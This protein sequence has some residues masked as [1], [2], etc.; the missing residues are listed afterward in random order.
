MLP[1]PIKVRGGG[2]K[3]DGNDEGAGRSRKRD[4][5]DGAVKYPKIGERRALDADD[6]AGSHRHHS[7]SRVSMLTARLD[8]TLHRPRPGSVLEDSGS[9]ELNHA[10]KRMRRRRERRLQ[11]TR[12][13]EEKYARLLADD[14]ADYVPEP[15]ANKF[16]PPQLQTEHMPGYTGAK[17]HLMSWERDQLKT[18]EGFAAEQARLSRT[19][20]TNMSPAFD[21]R[22]LAKAREPF[23]RRAD[24]NKTKGAPG[25]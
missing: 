12:R 9:R 16:A 21:A 24:L 3:R 13:A 8:E 18:P 10:M 22:G 2:F 5:D 20:G 4:T 14:S 6:P 15:E 1:T 11:H 25:L 23:K 17:M 19:L 7:P